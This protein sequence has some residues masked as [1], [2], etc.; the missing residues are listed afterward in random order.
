MKLFSGIKMCQSLFA[1]QG[2]YFSRKINLPKSTDLLQRIENPSKKTNE[3]EKLVGIETDM[4]D[5]DPVFLGSLQNNQ[6][7][8]EKDE[9]SFL[10]QDKSNKKTSPYKI[11]KHKIIKDLEKKQSEE[12]REMEPEFDIEVGELKKEMSQVKTKLKKEKQ[13]REDRKNPN[14]EDS[15]KFNDR[16]QNFE[17]KPQFQ[18]N[19]KTND[20]KNGFQKIDAA[21]NYSKKPKFNADDRSPL[22]LSNF[23]NG[24]DDEAE[25]EDTPK[26]EGNFPKRKF[27]N[28]NRDNNYSPKKIYNSDGNRDERR[29]NRDNNWQD[30]RTKN[31]QG[32]NSGYK[33]EWTPRPPREYSN[34]NKFIRDSEGENGN[35][36]NRQSQDRP[37]Y[38][39]DYKPKYENKSY[40]KDNN[41]VKD[42][43]FKKPWKSA[44]SSNYKSDRQFEQNGERTPYV[45]KDYSKNSEYKGNRE[46]G[47]NANASRF[48]GNIQ[49]GDFRNERS[50]F[51]NKEG[52][53][54]KYNKQVSA[55]K[56]FESDD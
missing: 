40:S 30:N 45:K 35:N 29:S 39:N 52:T 17:G 56:D 21:E 49:K 14:D 48:P 26:F 13:V 54:P 51:G 31:Y 5:L 25:M 28:E 9:N 18:K 6:S 4:P 7:Y 19:P 34:N 12:N 8:V 41:Y 1:R 36:F 38:Q 53:S 32:E 23:G 44:D 37:K 55:E 27:N 24:E 15:I 2:F 33:K 42:G 11:P 3:Q 47:E 50:S 10:N 22:P 46:R 20:F 16:K 43:G